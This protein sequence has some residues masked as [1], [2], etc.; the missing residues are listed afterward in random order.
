MNKTDERKEEAK[1][2]LLEYIN[3]ITQPDRKAG[4]NKYKCPLCGS[5]NHGKGKSDGAF[6]FYPGTN[7]WS[8]FACG[9]G[10]DLVTLI[11]QVEGLDD[12]DAISE[13]VKRYGGG[14]IDHRSTARD[15]FTPEK[16]RTEKPKEKRPELRKAIEQGAAA[17]SGSKAAEYMIARGFSPEILAAY[18][19][20]QDKSGGVIIP[21]PGEDYCI[22]R[23]PDKEGQ[24]KYKKPSGITEPLFIAGDIAAADTVYFCEG[25][26]DAL[27]LI[28]AGAA[29]AVAI[30]GAGDSKLEELQISAL[31]VVV[32]DRDAESKKDE[33]T[34]LT[35]G[36]KT[37]QKIIKKK[38]KKGLE[39]L[40][41]YPPEPYKDANDILKANPEELRELVT[42]WR[43][44]T[45]DHIEAKKEAERQEI[46]ATSAGAFLGE[47]LEEME[48]SAERPVTKTGFDRLD[49]ALDGGLYP[50]LYV[51]GAISSLGKTTLTLQIADNIARQN[52]DVLFFSLEM[53]KSE[54]IARSISRLT[55]TE[56]QERGTP[57]AAKTTRAIMSRYTDIFNYSRDLAVFNAALEQYKTYAQN[58]YFI[59]GLG[60]VTFETIRDRAEKH[61][62]VTG[63]KPIVIIDYL[64]TIAPADPKATPTDKQNTDKNV[65][66]L[67]RL[68]R[69]N[70]L[71]VFC[72]SSFNRD[73]YKESAGMAS[74]KESGAIEYGSDVLLG[75]EA[76]GAGVTLKTAQ[77]VEEAKAKNPR[78]VELKILKNRN[79]ATGGRVSFEYFTMFNCFADIDQRPKPESKSNSGRTSKSKSKKASTNDDND[80]TLLDWDDEINDNENPFNV[81]EII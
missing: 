44:Q 10:G 64:Q 67:K 23:N 11:K 65:L 1:R 12:K 27:S 22:I 66:E 55:Y 21:Y 68:S 78:E 74:F 17:L 20:G 46:A 16:P 52:L 14:S 77:D 40:G 15:D 54:L 47:W 49:K 43:Q 19:I 73:N 69:D 45:I 71:I 72:I 70:D 80:D 48:A 56:A 81:I 13:A 34:G 41:V 24:G 2:H 59:H 3:S 38:K 25:Q 76:Y 62:K 4:A 39:G 28:Q 53:S 35:P 33:K 37:A 60:N 36:Q 7:T 61:I 42:S 9:Q 58:I 50:G 32:V 57:Q 29:C 6:T 31:C 51:I 26:L 30:G 5:G 18:Q 79:G 75:L 63:R 8:C